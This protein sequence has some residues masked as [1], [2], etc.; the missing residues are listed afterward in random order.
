M[1]RHSVDELASTTQHLKYLGVACQ[2]TT[3][4][5]TE[6]AVKGTG[7]RVAVMHWIEDAKGQPVEHPAGTIV[8]RHIVGDGRTAK[9]KELSQLVCAD[10]DEAREFAARSLALVPR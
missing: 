9:F 6:R 10:M 4:A 7:E 3:F 5:R 1:K 2:V 8:A